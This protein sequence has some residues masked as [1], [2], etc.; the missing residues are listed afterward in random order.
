MWEWRGKQQAALSFSGNL[1]EKG[2]K[3]GAA[4]EGTGDG[5]WEIHHLLKFQSLSQWN[6]YDTEWSVPISLFS[7]PPLHRKINTDSWAKCWDFC[8]KCA[9]EGWP[10]QFS[11]AQLEIK[12]QTRIINN[13]REYTKIK[14]EIVAPTTCG[15]TGQLTLVTLYNYEIK[16]ELEHIILPYL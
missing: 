8:G 15:P 16:Q 12:A 9:R 14:P 6:V 10:E 11:F 7:T 2:K 3:H 4:A 1:E 13:I 5:L